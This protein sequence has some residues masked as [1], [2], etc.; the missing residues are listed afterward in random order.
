MHFLSTTSSRQKEYNYN[1]FYSKREFLPAAELARTLYISSTWR[2][3][4]LR[5][6]F[7]PRQ[8]AADRWKSIN[9]GHFD[10]VITRPQQ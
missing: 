3:I 7:R 6:M 9:I 4:G 2:T 10:C 1:R 5:S 8:D